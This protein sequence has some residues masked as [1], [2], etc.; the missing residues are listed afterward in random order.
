MPG[1]YVPCIDTVAVVLG[2]VFHYGAPN[3]PRRNALL[4]LS[5]TASTEQDEGSV[6]LDRRSDSDGWSVFGGAFDPGETSEEALMRD[7]SEE[8]GPHIESRMRCS[9]QV[10]PSNVHTHL[11]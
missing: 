11:R 6:V 5:V 4:R 7:V 1:P 3:S 10:H 9:G 2:T 8:T